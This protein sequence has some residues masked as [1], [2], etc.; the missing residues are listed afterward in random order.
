MT[1]FKEGTFRMGRCTIIVS[2]D[3]GKWHMSIS[4][5][6]ASPSYK[7][8]KEARYKLI[9][10]NVTMAQIFPPKEEFVNVHLYCHHLWEIDNTSKL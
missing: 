5:P 8:I 2:I 1:D 7:E 9:P 10:D 3:N 6:T 4:T